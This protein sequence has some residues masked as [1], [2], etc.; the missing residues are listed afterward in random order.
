[1]IKIGSI[2]KESRY[3]NMQFPLVLESRDANYK[4]NNIQLQEYIKK[5]RENIL[6]ACSIYGA[7][8]FE[9]MEIENC[10]EWASVSYSLGLKET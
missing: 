8:L 1:M 9:G 3:N 10:N 6:K 2:E 7:I 4:M 5:N